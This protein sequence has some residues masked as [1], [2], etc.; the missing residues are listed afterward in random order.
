ML[1]VM[2]IKCLIIEQDQSA[3][4]IIKKVGNDFD[5]IEFSHISENQNEVFDRILKIKPEIIFINIETTQ[6]NFPKF[7]SEISQYSKDKP[8]I[9]ALSTT[10]DKAYDAYQYNFSLYLL[11]PLTELD[12]RKRLNTIMEYYPKKEMETICLKSHKDFH[13]LNIKHILYLKADNNT[14]DFYMDDGKIIGAYKT[15][16]VFENAMPTNFYRI[17]KSY[18]VN[19]NC[20][21]RINFGKSTCFIK[22]L[23][24]IPFTKTFI[25]NI[26]E[27]NELLSKKAFFVPT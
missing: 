25:D 24:K 13:Y 17:H 20:I 19:I 3:V 4:D 10:K 9:I 2:A 27:M 22:N 11:K 8:H 12:I 5:Q 21:S 15:L 7:I 1:E 14:T 18:I 16:K 23:H 6:I 26:L